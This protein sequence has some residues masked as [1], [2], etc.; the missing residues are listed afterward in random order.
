VA[1]GFLLPLELLQETHERMRLER[2]LDPP[3]AFGMRWSR[4]TISEW[5]VVEPILERRLERPQ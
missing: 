2:S 3:R 4:V 1:V 5:E